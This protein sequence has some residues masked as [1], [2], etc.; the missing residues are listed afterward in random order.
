MFAWEITTV[1]LHKELLEIA[2]RD[3]RIIENNTR[4]PLDVEEKYPKESIIRV[5]KEMERMRKDARN[6]HD[7]SVRDSYAD[8]IHNIQLGQSIQVLISVAN[9]AFYYITSPQYTSLVLLLQAIVSSVVG[10]VSL[11]IRHRNYPRE[12]KVL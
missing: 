7:S 11:E 4:P 3:L 12:I 6:F 2:V 8:F 9:V 1:R 10:V 5:E